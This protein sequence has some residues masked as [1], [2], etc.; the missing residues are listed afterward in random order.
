MVGDPIGLFGLEIARLRPAPWTWPLITLGVVRPQTLAQILF[1]NT[2]MWVAAFIA[3]GVNFAWPS[4]LVL[5]KPS[6]APF[7]LIGTNRRTWW[8]ALGVLAVAS[9][10]FGLAMWQDYLTAIQNSSV[11]PGYALV[12]VPLMLALVIARLGRTRRHVDA[13][14]APNP[15]AGQVAEVRESTA[16]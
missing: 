4:V 14:S 5:F 2:N 3:M 9:V 7:A 1:G 12:T 15:P 6:L 11:T 10:P 8:M 13:R 16:N